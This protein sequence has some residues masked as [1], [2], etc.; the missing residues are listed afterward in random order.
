MKKIY[1]ALIILISTICFSISANAYD[2]LLNSG[3]DFEEDFLLW[4][5]AYFDE[6]SAYSGSGAAFVSNPFGQEQNGLITHVLEY[7]DKIHLEAGKIYTLSGA[8][9]NPMSDFSPRVDAHAELESH[10][11]TIIVKVYGAGDEWAEFTTNFYA[12]ETGYYNLAF[13]F[14]KGVTDFGFFADDFM[15]VQSDLSISTLSLSGPESIVIP[16]EG[17]TKTKYIPTFETIDG[18]EI[19]ILTSSNIRF[20]V[21]DANGVY[22]NNSEMMLYVSSEAVADTIV[23]LDCY[24]DNFE[25]LSVQS[26]DVLLT[27]NLLENSDFNDGDKNWNS[28]SYIDIVDNNIYVST[29]DYN[30][31]GFYTTMFYDKSLVLEKDELYVLHA[32]IKSDSPQKEYPIYAKNTSFVQ[33]DTVIFNITDISGDEWT[34]V[35]SAFIPES[36][37]IYNLAINFSSAYDCTFLIDN[38]NLCVER[39]KPTY[40]TLHA[41][42]NIAV[43]DVETS[44]TLSALVRDQLGNIIEEE[45]CYLSLDNQSQSVLFNASSN[46]LTISPDAQSGEYILRGSCV[47]YPDIKASIPITIS[48]EY[49]GDGG[50]ENKRVNE[51]WVTSSPYNTNF[52][53]RDDGDSKK[54]YTECYGDY[55]ILLN[56][57]Y[58]H[59]LAG[60]PYVFNIESLA[61]TNATVTVFVENMD[62]ETYPLVQFETN[63]ESQKIN[64]ELFLLEQDIIGRI[65]LYIQSDFGEPFISVI[66]NISLKKAIIKVTNP[67]VSGQLYVNG[68]ARAEFAFYNSIANTTSTDSAVINWYLGDSLS[69]EFV[70]L[71]EG[72]RYIYFDTEFDGKYVYFDVTPVCPVTGFSGETIKSAPFK[73]SYMENGSYTPPI[74]EEF[75]PDIS[76]DSSSTDSNPPLSQFPAQPFNDIESHWG[77]DYIK[78]LYKKG[79]INGKGNGLFY[80][81]DSISRAE[82]SKILSLVFSLRAKTQT[83]YFVDVTPDMWYYPYINSLY[84]NGITSGT[85]SNTFSPDKYITRQEFAVFAMRLYNLFKED[86]IENSL[87]NKILINDEAYIKPWAEASV[88]FVISNDIMGINYQSCFLPEQFTTRAE[89]CAVICR[90]YD[91]IK[92]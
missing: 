80:P 36:T 71:P 13:H 38:I 42:G 91:L 25:N 30:I 16:T 60:T 75:N 90:L 9:M 74:E 17:E 32:R 73:I 5:G 18:T 1:V 44:F 6:S 76:D 23:T 81:D 64:P 58:V 79:Y 51:W 3:F 43:P 85:S 70:Q 61:S 69:G 46:T 83:D 8:V 68:Y 65:F 20:N 26:I 67:H 86:T 22:F 39:I 56:N 50:F 55:F 4:S 63:Q 57:S 49:I 10:A 66:D 47:N 88:D 21:S 84:E 62:G 29:N 28:S 27:N 19:N 92:A 40:I 72:S 24:L 34:D 89:A 41:P 59:L 31:F 15:L 53:I 52:S 14:E 33:N 35:F 48:H 7:Y 78:D 11:N 45:A 77:K 54:A 82:V 87:F 2:E 12:S 37:G